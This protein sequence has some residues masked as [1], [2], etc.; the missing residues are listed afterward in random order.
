M[1][2]DDKN[3]IGL[4]PATLMVAGNMM[5]S[6]VFML[7]ANLAAIGG[8]TILGWLITICGSIALALVFAKNATLS[9]GAGGPYAYTKLAFGDYMGFQTNLVYWIAT[10]VGNVGLAVAGLG[11]LSQFFPGLK[12]PLV[13]ALTQISVIWLLAYANIRGARI[14]SRIQSVTTIFAL[15]PIL[16]MAFLGWFWFN[17]ATYSAAWNV[18]GQS[19][20]SAIGMT[21]NF[22]LWS[23]IG[24]ETA[25]VSAAVVKDPGKNVPIATVAGVLIAA[26]CYILSSTVIMGIIPNPELVASS[27][28]FADAVVLAL[29]PTAGKAV[30]LCAAVGCLGALGG[31][32]LM[33]GQTANAAA[34]DGLFPNVFARENKWGSPSA[35]LAIIAALMSLQVLFTMSPTAGQQFGKIASVTVI[36]TLLPYIYSSAALKI[37]AYKKL[38]TERQYIVYSF[39]GLFACL[40]CL[41]ALIGSDARMTRW[42][43]VFT[44]T[45]VIFYELM[46]S[47]KREIEVGAV[48]A[49]GSIPP[50][51]RR[52]A[53]TVTIVCLCAAYWIS[54]GSQHGVLIKAREWMY[55]ISSPAI[56]HVIQ[57]LGR[58]GG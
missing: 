17:R 21:L 26:V 42:A 15:I 6:G 50:W 20:M 16:G 39:I 12:Q 43:L 13:M 4:V 34:K 3:K 52:V 11:Y 1:A 44:I 45:T 55:G 32:T 53:L 40:Y 33:S 49:G 23:F 27:A 38:A 56:H 31:W 14:V 25:S 19:A 24:V 10:V 9:P 29:G 5:G 22:T 18:T 37:L 30:A 58:H 8:I 54:I 2:L 36:L 46:Y 35:G 48:H 28:P 51:V 57:A 41:W 7:P 47:R